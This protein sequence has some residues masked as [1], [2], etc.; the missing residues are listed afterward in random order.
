M[1]EQVMGRDAMY[2][3]TK[4]AEATA[5]EFFIDDRLVAKVAA[6]AAL[7]G[8]DVGAQKPEFAGAA[9]N[10]L[11]DV[12]LRPPLGVVRQH[13][14]FRKSSHRIAK[15]LQIVVHPGRSRLNH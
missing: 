9:P 8:R 13:F 4:T 1:I 12:S 6:G 11:A 3:L 5:V 7:L 10:V 15:D 2:A 14:S